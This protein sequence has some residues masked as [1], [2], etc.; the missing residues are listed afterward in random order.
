[1]VNIIFRKEEADLK[2]SVV[3]TTKEDNKNE[4]PKDANENKKVAFK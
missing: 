2:P 1:V 4:E 3:E